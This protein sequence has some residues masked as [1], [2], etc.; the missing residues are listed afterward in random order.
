MRPQAII[1]DY[2]GVLTL[3]D[4][5]ANEYAAAEEAL[6]LAQGELY[7][8]LW[9][10]APWQRVKRGE[11]LEAEF[12]RTILPTCGLEAA[13]TPYGPLAF[14]LQEEADEA[15][16]GLV[17]RL[18]PG[19]RLVL[20]SNATLSY[21][22]RWLAFGLYD[23]FDV[24]VNSARVGLAKPDPAIYHLTLAWLGLAPGDCLF[25]DNLPRNTVAAEALGLPS[26]V[27]T[28]AEALEAELA[29]HGVL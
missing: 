4:R 22:A 2:D 5:R 18:R 1:F 28:S 19:Y 14:L 7:R 21:E 23:L 26:L 25:I 29:A 17:R 6:R 15:V 27:F 11:I 12:W 16:L 8:R 3:S 10:V 20:L 13:D 24:V 9:D